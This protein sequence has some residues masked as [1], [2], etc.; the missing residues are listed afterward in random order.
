MI[1][2]DSVRKSYA[3]GTEVLKG[4]SFTCDKRKIY[5]LVGRNGVGKS[6]LINCIAGLLPVSQGR[7]EILGQSVSPSNRSALRNVG[8]VFEDH[9]M[10]EKFT[11]RE[12]LEFTASLYKITNIN[13]RIDE[14]VQLLELPTQKSKYIESYSSGTRSKIALAC[15]L[16]HSPDILILD[17][18]FNGLDIQVSNR[19]FAYLKEYVAKGK[20]ALITTHQVNIISE[21]SDYVLILKNGMID[22]VYSFSELLDAAAG[23]TEERNQLGAFLERCIE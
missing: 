1:K 8:F 7:I 2:V 18:P 20:C 19:L 3:G 16:I 23:V 11:A 5:S 12:Q 15:A 21:L 22:P 13:T 14:L 6:T 10:V 4:I 9:S 17:E